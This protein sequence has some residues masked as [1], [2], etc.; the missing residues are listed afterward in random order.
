MIKR[1][2]NGVP[3]AKLSTSNEA[4]TELKRKFAELWSFIKQVWYV[5]FI[6]SLAWFSYWI[7]QENVILSH[8]VTQSN[9]FNYVGF[10]VSMIAIIVKGWISKSNK[11]NNEERAKIFGSK[12]ASNKFHTTKGE[13]PSKETQY[14]EFEHLKPQTENYS[15]I[16]EVQ[17]E[18]LTETDIDS[19]RSPIFTSESSPSKADR[20]S[21]NTDQEIPSDCLLCPNLANCD[22]RKKRSKEPGTPC[23]L[24]STTSNH[25]E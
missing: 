10:T 16:D 13:M 23:P 7:F 24:E 15:L 21:Q 20:V 1:S 19:I 6:W 18:Q 11:E 22:Q 8:P 17:T 12:N 2:K 5:P 14:L 4:T 25:S 9:Y 3:I